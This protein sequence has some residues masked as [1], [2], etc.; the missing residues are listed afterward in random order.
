[1]ADPKPGRR[2]GMTRQ[3]GETLKTEME[4]LCHVLV[5]SGIHLDEATASFQRTFLTEVLTRHNG[6]QCNA[7]ASQDMH[8]NTLAKL[9]ADLKLKPKQFKKAR[10]RNVRANEQAAG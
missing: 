4:D 2:T 9:C 5:D 8:R 7:A 10:S 3:P 6:H 1:M